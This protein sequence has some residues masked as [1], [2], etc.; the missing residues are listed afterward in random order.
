MIPCGGCNRGAPYDGAYDVMRQCRLCWLHANVESYR[1]LWDAAPP[2]E[3]NLIAKAVH[4]AAAVVKHVAAGMPEVSDE[5]R[6]R[7]VAICRSNRCGVYS[8]ADNRCLACGCALHNSF[9][10]DKTRW[11]GERCPRGFWC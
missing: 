9:L 3:P 2:P 5:E 11:A 7:R 1:A 10:G 6:E 8:A 4:Y